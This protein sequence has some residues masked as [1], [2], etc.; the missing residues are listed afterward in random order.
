MSKHKMSINMLKY[1]LEF[2]SY[3]AIEDYYNIFMFI[4]SSVPT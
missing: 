3:F 2:I 1:F 4:A